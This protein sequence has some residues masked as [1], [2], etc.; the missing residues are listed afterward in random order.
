M[1]TSPS[2][3]STLMTTSGSANAVLR[4]AAAANDDEEEEDN[5]VI[6][7]SA[8]SKNDSSGKY[9]TIQFLIN[10]ISNHANECGLLFASSSSSTFAWFSEIP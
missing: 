4:G 1:V 8:E 6:V 7:G 2:A 5:E 9:R 3:S 10:I